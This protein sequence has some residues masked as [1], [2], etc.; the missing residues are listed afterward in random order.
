MDI[1]I[2]GYGYGHLMN[3]VHFSFNCRRICLILSNFRRIFVQFPSNFC[4]NVR[5]VVQIS[6][7]CRKSWAL[8]QELEGK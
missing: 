6:S 5:F 2:Y 3:P 8:G 4:Q 1:W 7:K